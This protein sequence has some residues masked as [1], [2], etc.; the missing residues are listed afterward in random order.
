MNRF[1]QL[2]HLLNEPNETLQSFKHHFKNQID[3]INLIKSIYL[4]HN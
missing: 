3:Q 4:N 2:N 1:R